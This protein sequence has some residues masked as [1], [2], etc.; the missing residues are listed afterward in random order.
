M[1]GGGHRFPSD[2]EHPSSRPLPIIDDQQLDA[3]AALTS[4]A[5][6]GF[7]RPSTGV[8]DRYLAPPIPGP[9]SLGRQFSNPSLLSTTSAPEYSLSYQS[10]AEPRR[11]SYYLQQDNGRTL[12]GSYQPGLSANSTL[13][14][15]GG[16]S[17]LA[18]R[19]NVGYQRVSSADY[20][21]G[22][23]RHASMMT[24][25]F[26]RSQQYEGVEGSALASGPSGYAIATGASVAPYLLGL[27]RSTSSTI[28]QGDRNSPYGDGQYRAAEQSH[29][30]TLSA[31]HLSNAP[32]SSDAR[33]SSLVSG[34]QPSPPGA[35]YQPGTG[36]E[37]TYHGNAGL[38]VQVAFSAQGY[39]ERMVDRNET[40]AS[41]YPS[42]GLSN[43][44]IEQSQLA[45]QT[46]L[47]YG[48]AL[49]ANAAMEEDDDGHA[50][51][52]AEEE[53]GEEDEGEMME[54]ATPVVKGPPM[55]VVRG[56]PEAIA[57]AQA[58]AR[59]EAERLELGL[60]QS[61]DKSLS[62]DAEPAK[63]KITK[64][65]TTSP[66][67]N[68]TKKPV[69]RKKPTLSST[70]ESSLLT[71][72]AVR[73]EFLLGEKV[74]AITWSEYENLQELMTQFCRV[75]LLS[76]F[77]RPVSVLHPEV[78][79]ELRQVW[80]TVDFHLTPTCLLRCAVGCSLF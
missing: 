13:N 27:E 37:S 72:P 20:G 17:D 77:S 45:A 78:S 5:Q 61:G 74:P 42:N 30:Q 46:I 70:P 43:Q 23:Y 68:P 80:H 76:E 4:F 32:T 55:P 25:D 9:E 12:S 22:N 41:V 31:S 53:D 40:T 35:F 39:S 66:K 10:E 24:G 8:V 75:P 47:G 18:L 15:G 71:V 69:H 62:D 29:L 33:G 67:K 2:G 58:A 73:R 65:A 3:V 63:K 21:E 48:A 57:R 19:G 14:V 16:Q 51:V 59:L 52:E 11:P 28:Y 36:P 79:R 6:V 7:T 50:V 49:D 26:R 64:K 1:N 60:D 34:R 44:L 54:E 56:K 38:A